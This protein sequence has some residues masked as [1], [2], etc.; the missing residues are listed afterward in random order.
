LKLRLNQGL[1]QDELKAKL[2]VTSIL[3][4]TKK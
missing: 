2:I 3:K 4:T 1:K